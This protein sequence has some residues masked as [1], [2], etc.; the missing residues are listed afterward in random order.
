[1]PRVRLF[2]LAALQGHEHDPKWANVAP[3]Q[4]WC[5]V[6][7]YDG[8]DA[9]RIAAEKL[10]PRWFKSPWLDKSL[11][12]VNPARLDGPMPPYGWVGDIAGRWSA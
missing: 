5:F 12:A 1:M 6:A 10:T 2:G 4:R 8:D 3:S 9:R 11:T 7:A